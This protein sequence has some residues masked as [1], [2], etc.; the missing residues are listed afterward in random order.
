MSLELTPEE[1]AYLRDIAQSV[2]VTKIVCTR[3]VKGKGGDTFL[4]FS[5]VWDS[6]QDDGGQDL[7]SNL[8]DEEIE[9]EGQAAGRDLTDA[10]IAACFV[11]LTVEEQAFTNA[12]ANGTVSSDRAK[13]H[14]NRSR[15]NYLR[16]MIELKRDRE[17][18][19]RKRASNT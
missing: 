13:A 2:R 7:V 14:I 17:E 1:R 9:I 15:Q 10:K 6:V 11:A 5:A 18:R 12:A 4:G 8:E 19:D 3:S 16:K